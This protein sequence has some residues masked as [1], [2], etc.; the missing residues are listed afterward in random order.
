M[1]LLGESEP[2]SQ[3]DM[4]LYLRTPA[5]EKGERKVLFLEFLEKDLRLEF[6]LLTLSIRNK[7]LGLSF[8]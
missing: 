7:C 5:G 3:E 1:R 8:S 6:G 2:G 4:H